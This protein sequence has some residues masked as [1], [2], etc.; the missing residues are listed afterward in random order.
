MSTYNCTF[1]SLFQVKV[2]DPQVKEEEERKLAEEFKKVPKLAEEDDMMEVVYPSINLFIYIYLSI[3]P[4][5][6][7][8]ILSIYIHI[9]IYRYL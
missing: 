1:F 6:H 9:Y 5:N 3:Y 7:L 4:S 2:E 8:S